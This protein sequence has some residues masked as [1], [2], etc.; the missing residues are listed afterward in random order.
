M[1]ATVGFQVLRCVFHANCAVR[2]VRALRHQ[3]QLR[4]TAPLVLIE[5]FEGK[6]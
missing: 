4:Y 5:D 2:A 6:P 1:A 3:R